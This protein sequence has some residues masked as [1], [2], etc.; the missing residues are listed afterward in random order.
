MACVTA[1]WL[2]ATLPAFGQRSDAAQTRPQ[3]AAEPNQVTPEDEA[4]GESKLSTTE[5]PHVAARH[6]QG[7]AQDADLERAPAVTA[8]TEGPKDPIS[9]DLWVLLPAVVAI[10]LAVFL[11]QVVPALVVGVLVGAYMLVPCLP[12][13]DAYGQLNSIIAG[14]RLAAERYVLGELTDPTDGYAHITIIVFT[15]IIGFTIGVIGRNGGTEGMV[16]LVAGK[17]T[18]PRRGG[19]TAWAAGLVVFF[20]DYA[21]TMIVG[22]TMQSVFDR[23][24][25]SRAKLAYIVDSTA[26]PVASIA[27]IG[28]WV[29][30]EIGYIKT[31]IDAVAE[32]GAPAFLIDNQGNIVDGW[33][34]FLHS[35]PYRF[36][37]ILA[38]VLVFLVA[39]T[40]RDFGPMRQSERRLLS[41]IEPDTATAESDAKPKQQ[42]RP[43]WWLGLIPIL[44]LVAG[45]VVV[46]GVTGYHA[47]GDPAQMQE[48]ASWWRRA[49]DIASAGDAYL[50]IFYGAIL[51][52]FVAVILTLLVRVCSTRDVVDAGL[53]GMTR[54]FPAMVI[55]VLAWA[56]SAVLQ[57]LKLGHVVVS[58]LQAIQF[59]PVWL[60]LAIFLSAAVISFATGTSWGTM[61]ILCPLTVEISARLMTGLEQGEAL[62]LFYA[63]V[64]SVLAGAV[65]G[66]H[67]SPISDT[68]VLSSIAS[69][70]RHEEHVWTQIPY[71]LVAA[72]GA[73]ALGDVLCSVYKQPWYL[74]LGAGVVFL[75]LVVYVAGRRPVPSFDFADV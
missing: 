19:L 39:L 32:S 58:H 40:G 16:R 8:P 21:N 22:P 73:M 26:A 53:N 66:D 72:I 13:G 65:F 10:L 12:A 74:G 41:K 62:A 30:A 70:C 29:G 34:A 11:R 47:A 9:Y 31:G 54:M 63:S 28:T 43:R 48:P 1:V 27:L 23:V 15:L 71:A 2:G 50:S 38:L 44:V 59:P 25:L 20:D 45:T 42:A 37:P 17:T 60:P 57:D 4:V 36:Y 5:S 3:Q 33:Q 67:C 64:G 75:L 69:G 6:S 18:S 14:F 61:G 56:L 7:Q 46:L 52:A 49:A 68:T 35:I 55:L 24:K 51:S